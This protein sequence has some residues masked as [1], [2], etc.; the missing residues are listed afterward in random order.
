MSNTIITED[1]IE[2]M[3]NKPI[4]DNQLLIQEIQKICT[5]LINITDTLDVRSYYT[6]NDKLTGIYGTLSPIYKRF[7]ALKENYEAKYYNYLKLQADINNEKFVAVTAQHKASEYIAPLRLTRD[8]LEGYIDSCSKA[9]DTCRIR[10]YESKK[11]NKY[12]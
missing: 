12:E 3:A 1:Q 2:E 4:S 7:R 8:I 9:I 10:I 6:Y 11:D 5:N